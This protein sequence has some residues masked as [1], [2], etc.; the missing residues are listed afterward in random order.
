MQGS[1]LKESFVGSDMTMMESTHDINPFSS[2]GTSI[3]LLMV[4]SYCLH[5][6]YSKLL[7]FGLLAFLALY[8]PSC[9]SS[10]N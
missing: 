4:V 8:T 6:A 7:R 3:Y 9:L 2:I 1:I 5:I 10:V